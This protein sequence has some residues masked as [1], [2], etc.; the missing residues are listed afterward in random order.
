MNK[1]NRRLTPN[2][3]KMR[4]E[5][6]PEEKHLW[7]DFLKKMPFTVNRQKVIWRYIADFYIAK[8]KIVIEIDGAQHYDKENREY[9]KARDEYFKE[10]G[11]LVLRYKNTDIYT[12]FEG[13][14]ADIMKAI[15]SPD[16]SSVPCGTAS[17][18]GEAQR[19]L[20]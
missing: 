12:K 10:Q 4:K 18:Q 20:S 6:T 19:A 13:V 2:A 17:P 1:N 3:Q 16:T 9:D 15:G 11:I 7:F 5:M 14:C 8:Y